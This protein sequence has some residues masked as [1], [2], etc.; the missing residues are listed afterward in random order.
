MFVPFLKLRSTWAFVREGLV[1]ATGLFWA[2]SLQAATS[3]NAFEEA[4]RLFERGKYADAAQAYEQLIASGQGNATIYYNQGTAWLQ[5]GRVG[6]AIHALNQ[7]NRLNPNDSD[8]ANNLRLAR[9]KSGVNVQE[10]FLDL[11]G[12]IP[13]NVWTI[14][15]SLCLSLCLLLKAS[16]EL[17]LSWATPLKRFLMAL[18]AASLFVCTGALG[19][20]WNQI[21]V[22]RVV[23]ITPEA[24]VRR[25]P[26]VESPVVFTPSDGIQLTI[27]ADK[28][29]WVQVRD[30]DGQEGWVQKSQVKQ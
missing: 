14:A 21:L 7:A 10:S 23:V 11:L 8:I 5:A 20:A 24:V 4:N 17:G 3:S 12:K 18:A 2:I 9:L 30:N 6:M 22:R 1:A 25:G 29:D 15:S 28:D 26:L 13:L 27:L 19:V 16:I